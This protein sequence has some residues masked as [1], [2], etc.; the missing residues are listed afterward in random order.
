MSKIAKRIHYE[1]IAAGGNSEKQKIEAVLS[2]F[3]S[4]DKNLDT[5]LNLLKNEKREVDQ[6]RN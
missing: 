5:I 1:Q 4:L 2:V 3:D 6:R